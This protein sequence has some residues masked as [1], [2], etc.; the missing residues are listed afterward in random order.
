MPPVAGRGGLEILNVKDPQS[1][2][3]LLVEDNL[4]NLMMA[5]GTLAALGYEVT[6]A[7]NGLEAVEAFKKQAFDLILMDLVMP[8]MDGC[9]AAREILAMCREQDKTPPSIVALSA[10]MELA[11]QERCREVGITTW[12]NKPIMPAEFQDLVRDL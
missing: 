1:L 5:Q 6:T 8:V 9:E 3:I 10:T 4:V 2:Q 7:G 11:E 12:L